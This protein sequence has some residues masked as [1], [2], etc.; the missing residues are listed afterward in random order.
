LLLRL[1]GGV[2]RHEGRCGWSPVTPWRP[3]EDRPGSPRACVG[4]WR[5]PAGE[6]EGRPRSPQ[7][8]PAALGRGR[9]RAGED[10]LEPPPGAAQPRA[11]RTGVAGVFPPRGDHPPARSRAGRDHDEGMAARRRWAGSPGTRPARGLGGVPWR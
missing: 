2:S 6:V 3:W 10:P 7:E 4:P 8:R 11:R 1:A 9:R 5:D